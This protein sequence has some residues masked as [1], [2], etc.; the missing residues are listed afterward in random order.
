MRR[1]RVSDDAKR[2]A[3]VTARA[4]TWGRRVGMR[5]TPRGVTAQAGRSEARDGESLREGKAQESRGGRRLGKPG[6][7]AL[8]P[9]GSPIAKASRDAGRR[10]LGES[11]TRGRREARKGDGSRGGNPW[12]EAASGVSRARRSALGHRTGRTNRTERE[13]EDGRPDDPVFRR[14]ALSQR[15]EANRRRGGAA[16]RRRRHL[17]G[18]AL[19]GEPRGRAR[20]RYTGEADAGSKAS[21]RA[22]TARTQ[23]DP[24]G[25]MPG[26]GGSARPGC[27]D[28]E[29]NLARAEC[30]ACPS[31]GGSRVK[32]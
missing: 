15:P 19:K 9:T 8:Q 10:R 28:G 3:C 4:G 2:V 1:R 23:H 21:R 27:V 6:G 29:E 13:G 11:G 31:H 12:S 20:L 16:E 26:G 5:A 32:L 14:K 22:G 17:S 18:E 24:G 30:A 7:V 25:G